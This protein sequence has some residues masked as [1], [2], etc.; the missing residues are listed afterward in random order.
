MRSTSRGTRKI[1]VP[2]LPNA[3]YICQRFPRSPT[4]RRRR[5]SPTNWPAAAILRRKSQEL[6]SIRPPIHVLIVDDDPGQRTLMRFLV[7]HSYPSAIITEAQ[8]GHAALASYEAD[9]ADVIITDIHMPILDGIALTAAVR[10]RHSSLPIIVVSGASDGEALAHHAGASRYLDK[11]ALATQLS[12][13]LVDI[14]SV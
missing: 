13:L 4:G 6:I 11:A 7:L 12:E 5:P 3:S 14:L 2:T 9:G 8:D 10:A 1:S